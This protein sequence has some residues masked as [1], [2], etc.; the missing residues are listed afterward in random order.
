[1]KERP[2]MVTYEEAARRL[3][4]EHPEFP[5]TAIQIQRMCNNRQLTCM[6]HPSCG[7]QRRTY[8]QVNYNTLVAE[9]TKRLKPAIYLPDNA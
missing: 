3:A 7:V 6:M 9:L 4:V 8:G 5:Y 1:M 2:T